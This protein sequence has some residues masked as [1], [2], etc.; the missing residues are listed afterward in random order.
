M[1]NILIICILFLTSHVFGEIYRGYV[2]NQEQKPLSDVLVIHGEN[3]TFSLENGFFILNSEAQA[4]SL[5]IYYAFHELIKVNTS[6]FL[7]DRTF[8][9]KPLDIVLPSFTF[10]TKKTSNQLPKSQEKITISLK[11]QPAEKTNLA[12]VLTQEKSIQIEGTQLPGERQTASILGHSSR[13][14]LVMLDGIPLNTSGEDF[15]LASIPVE[16]VDEIEIYKNNVS[17]LSGGGGGMAGVINIKTKKTSSKNSE[18]SFTGNFGSYNFRKITTSSGFN[19]SN[20]TIYAV[21]S[22]QRSDNDFKYKIKKGNKWETLVREDNSKQSTNAMLNLSSKFKWFDLYYSGNLSTFNNELPGPTN[23]LALYNGAKIEGYDFYNDLKIRSKIYDVKNSLELYS[24]KKESNYTNLTATYPVSRADNDSKN[25]RMGIKLR[26]LIELSN[27]QLTLANSTLQ[28]S[29][30]YTDKINPSSNID[31][32]YQY[33]FASN[34]ITQYESN[35]DLFNYNLI[36]SLSYDK[37]N[38]FNDFTT[39]RLSGNVSY[40]YL[41]KPTFMFSYGSSFTLPSFYSL[42]WK[43]DSHALGNP[44]LH[45]EESKGYQLG[46]QLEYSSLSFKFNKSFNEIDNL[47]QWIQVQLQ[48]GIWKP[49]NIGSSELSNYEFEATWQVLPDLK[50]SSKAVISDTKNKT[51]LEDG[52]QSSFY[53]KHLVFIPD[54]IVNLGLDYT[55]NT[56]NFKIDYAMTGEQWTTQDNLIDPLSN[57]D[58]LNASISKVIN[59]GKFQHNL[60]LNFNNILN[61]YYETV[62]YRPQ[63]PFNWSLG[64]G[65]K[66]YIKPE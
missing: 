41:L 52:T 22:H 26:H 42:Y 8:I 49:V 63:A 54:Y 7:S 28:E 32:T 16:L 45:P 62:K 53:G 60:N 2:L 64:Y 56:Y 43:G 31:D 6:D 65:I 55:L 12:E 36:G 3:S 30:S 50:L 18:V 39:Y 10:S 4:D 29:Y 1:K 33:S 21:L 23:S 59:I 15:D 57:Y 61:N 19:I 11:N 46:L 58:L 35:L 34:M 13:H 25:N 47:I 37:H 51:R 14:T 17:S 24:I 44:D 40:D 48:G 5:I 66:Y 9:L 38:R 20:S 27:L